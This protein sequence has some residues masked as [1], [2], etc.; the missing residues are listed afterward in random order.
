MT[1]RAPEQIADLI[2]YSNGQA[3]YGGT[4][5]ELSRRLDRLFLDW[6]TECCAAEYVFPTFI[7]AA[8]LA[9]IDYLRS[10]PHLATF[11]VTLAPEEENLARFAEQSDLGSKGP[12][13]LLATSPIE[14]VLTPAACY[15]FYIH[16]QNRTL[17]QAL[18]LTTRATC[19]RR[20]REYAPLERQWSFSMREIVCIGTA[21]EV[22][23]FLGKCQ[24]RVNGYLQEIGLPVDWAHATDPFFQ[25]S[26]SSRYLAQ[27]LDPVKTEALFQG[28]LALSSI[29]FHRNYFGEAF[30]IL[31]DGKEAFS[32]CV[33]FGLERWM[34]AILTHFGPE[35]ASWPEFLAKSTK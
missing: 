25:P 35:P 28:R 2:W 33:A 8:E 6:A 9:R 26:R 16:F 27:K 31:R 17:S 12:I 34:S 7:S 29:N 14:D 11:P 32:G 3:A 4:L 22:K 10:F 13:R 20:E 18:Y 5:L 24:E 1:S 23:D 21:N 30:H 19:Y 15:H